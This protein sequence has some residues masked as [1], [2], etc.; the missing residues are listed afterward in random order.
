MK[1]LITLLLLISS[2]SLFA[3][4]N[5]KLWTDVTNVYARS[6]GTQ[7]V[8]TKQCRQLELNLTGM[9]Q[10]LSSAPFEF[11]DVARQRQTI[12]ELPMP[13]GSF[14]RFSIVESPVCAP[15][16][17]AKYP[18]TKTW[19]G[20]GID[21]PSA[22]VRLDVTPWGF[23]SMILSENGEIFI[24]PYSQQTTDLYICY[25]KNDAIR[26]GKQTACLYD[27]N[28]KWNKKQ[29][30]EIRSTIESHQ[31][32]IQ[33]SGPV[34]RKYD[35]ALACSGE[36]AA[37]FTA[38]NSVPAVHAAMVTTVNRVDG[39]YEKELAVRMVL[40][41]NNDTL[42]FFTLNTPYTNCNGST[43][44]GQNQTTITTRIGSAN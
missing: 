40:V 21:D 39:V 20:Q 28:D 29:A 30:E 4:N 14:Q 3:I 8:K 41:P 7:A 26:S 18:E 36:Y 22:T 10:L 32:K 9:K 17:A 1:K 11:T 5:G 15:E 16:L 25:N 31:N 6:A 38:T 13:D 24:D 42:I 34:L 27:E 37:V 33:A 23:H 35:L 19:A 44:L 43:M 2:N 12:L